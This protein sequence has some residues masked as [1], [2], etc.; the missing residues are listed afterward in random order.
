MQTMQTDVE[1]TESRR[2]RFDMELS[3]HIPTGRA[4]VEIKVTPFSQKEDETPKS[5][6]D[7]YGRFKGLKAFGGEGTEVQSRL[8]NEW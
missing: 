5:I 6:M 7:F 3:E 1:I 2:L 8:R 4:H